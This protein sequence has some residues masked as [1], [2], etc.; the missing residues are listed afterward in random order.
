MRSC[1]SSASGIVDGHLVHLCVFHTVKR[2]IELLCRRNVQHLYMWP[3]LWTDCVHLNIVLADLWAKKKTVRFRWYEVTS[4]LRN[5]V[6]LLLQDHSPSHHL[7]CK[8]PHRSL[9]YTLCLRLVWG[10]CHFDP[11]LP[12]STSNRIKRISNTL[13]AF[14]R[15]VKIFQQTT[16]VRYTPNTCKQPKNVNEFGAINR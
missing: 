1:C 3:R 6:L 9:K 11:S 8:P 13:P 10:L 5:T 16:K 15:C 7:F 12:M 14:Q 4:E 2:L